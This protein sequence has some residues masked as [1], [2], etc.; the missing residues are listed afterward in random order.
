VKGDYIVM[1]RSLHMKTAS[2]IVFLPKTS[3]PKR[4]SRG[5]I[6]EESWVMRE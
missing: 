3:I 2:P 6:F 1:S 5:G 4:K